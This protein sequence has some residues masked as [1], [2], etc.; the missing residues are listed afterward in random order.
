MEKQGLCDKYLNKQRLI[1]SPSSTI[2]G[3]ICGEIC[4]LKYPFFSGQSVGWLVSGLTAAGFLH[5]FLSFFFLSFTFS[6]YRMTCGAWIDSLM[7]LWGN[8]LAPVKQISSL[9]STSSARTV[10]SLKRACWRYEKNK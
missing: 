5:F 4:L 2:K 7:A 10:A 8:T 1:N 3:P 6:A 9:T